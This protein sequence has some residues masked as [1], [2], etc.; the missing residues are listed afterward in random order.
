MKIQVKDVF[1]LADGI[2]ELI[3]KELDIKVAF[4]VERNR[5]KIAEEFKVAN[6]VRKQII[7]K[8]K[9]KELEG[10][11]I[12]LKDDKVQSYKNELNELMEQEIDVDL[13]HIY[14]DELVGVSV[15]PRVIS[16]LEKILKEKE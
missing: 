7:D 15:K 14:L 8:Y 10:G 6:E 3:D 4:K 16:M 2:A 5:I 1:S 12:K 11:R 13:H 9:E